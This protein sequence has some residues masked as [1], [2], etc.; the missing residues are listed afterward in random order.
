M[1]FRGSSYTERVL[2]RVLVASRTTLVLSASVK[3][4]P[5]DLVEAARLDGASEWHVFKNVM[6][7][8]LLPAIAVV[9]TVSVIAAIRVFDIVYV[10]TGGNYNTDVVATRMYAEQFSYGNT[11]LASAIAIVLLLAAIPVLLANRAALRREDVVL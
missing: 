10:M 9:T 4:I 3:G 6:L 11:G 8:E 1:A 2:R 7:P 5:K